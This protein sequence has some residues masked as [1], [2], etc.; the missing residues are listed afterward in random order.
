MKKKGLFYSIVIGL[1]FLLTIGLIVYNLKVGM[2]ADGVTILL[3]CVLLL[4]V[5]L[6]WV[7]RAGKKGL[8]VTFSLIGVLGMAITLSGQFLNPWW[9]TIYNYPFRFET[10][11]FDEKISG[12][13]ASSDVAYAMRY[14]EKIHP[15]CMH[16]LPKEVEDRYHVV[17]NYLN[18]Q[19]EVEIYAVES[20]LRSILSGF[21]DG[22][23]N[24]SNWDNDSNLY[25][26][27]WYKHEINDDMLVAINGERLNTLFEERKSLY[28]FDDESFGYQRFKNDLISLS[29]LRVLGEDPSKG[30]IYTF[31]GSDGKEFDE[32]F[33]TEDFVPYS[34]YCSFNG[35]DTEALNSEKD[36]GESFFYSIDEEENYAALTLTSCDFNDAYC[37]CLKNMFTEVKEKGIGNVVVDLR[38]N[39]G[40]NSLVANE[41][42]KYLLIDSYKDFSSETRFGCFSINMGGGEKVN[43]KYGDLTFPGSVYVFTSVNTYS[44][45]MD[46]AMYISD[47]HLGTII[48]QASGNNPSSYGDIS[49]HYL[50]N[51]GLV[52]SVSIKKWHRIDQNKEG[53]LIT[54]DFWC[55]PGSE[56]A[57]LK[58]LIK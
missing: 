55:T 46:F 41:F 25:L 21:H 12:Y 37:E 17:L 45:A 48:G 13:A 32:T 29:A 56:Y 23:T 2:V 58:E 36:N 9:N 47:N 50:K 4:F 11:R 44:S 22:H 30:T 54:P 51:S 57:C 18:E 53:Q 31:L 14:V 20:L 24:V 16:G 52:L 27:Q 34:E 49:Q 26:K 3:A 40:G 15:L 1:L 5:V 7:R 28:C 8:K 42:L 33:Y 19:D 10:H 35:L 6:M 39:G 38:D 43:H